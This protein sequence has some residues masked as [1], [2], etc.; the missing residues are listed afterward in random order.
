MK[1]KRVQLE[2]LFGSRVSTFTS[3]TKVSA[4]VSPKCW[5]LAEGCTQ[6]FFS[7]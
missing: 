6:S 5:S 2:K 3:P 1:T 4:L 7:S